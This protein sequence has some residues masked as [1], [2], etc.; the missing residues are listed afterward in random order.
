MNI[1]PLSEAEEVAALL[2]AR[3]NVLDG[4]PYICVH[5]ATY[6]R[7]TQNLDSVDVYD[8]LDTVPIVKE[9][10]E[11]LEGT[12]CIECWLG[13]IS[14]KFSNSFRIAIIDTLLARRGLILP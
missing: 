12:S 1:A 6:I 3:H 13:V 2:Y 14:R 11:F 7:E 8:D 4:T 9:V 5:I 10:N